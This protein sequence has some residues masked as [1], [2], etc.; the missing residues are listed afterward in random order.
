MARHR[1]MVAEGVTGRRDPHSILNDSGLVAEL[2]DS[3]DP[4]DQTRLE[5]LIELV[6]VARGVR[7]GRPHRGRRP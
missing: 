4:Q 1:A 6:S 7:R 3:T 5:N 2:R